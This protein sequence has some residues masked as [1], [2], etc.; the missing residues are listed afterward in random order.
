V[1]AV[2]ASRNREATALKPG[3]AH[4]YVALSKDPQALDALNCDVVVEAVGT[5]GAIEQAIRA[6]RPGGRVILL[7]SS[8]GIGRDVDLLGGA[9]RR[10]VDV[11][12]AHI[13]AI[14]DREQSPGL[15]SYREEGET[16]LGL[17]S[18]GRLAVTDLVTWRAKPEACN[19]VYEVL[20]AGGAEHVGI[21]FDWQAGR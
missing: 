2:A 6:A 14:P 16:F 18:D 5:P 7:G 1:V 9:Q 12:G 15:W 21:V 3:G 13:S 11:I 20:A 17:L 4:A 10:G 8:R 19:A